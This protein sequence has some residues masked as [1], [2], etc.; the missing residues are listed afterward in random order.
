MN[1]RLWLWPGIKEAKTVQSWH[2][3]VPTGFLD[4]GTESRVIGGWAIMN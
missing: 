1:I 2:L 3:L 4:S